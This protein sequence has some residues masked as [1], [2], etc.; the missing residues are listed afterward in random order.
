[1]ATNDG[2]LLIPV[3]NKRVDTM[4]AGAETSQLHLL[5]IFN[6]FRIAITPFERNLGISVRVDEDVECA[7]TVQHGQESD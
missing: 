3:A 7:V 1:M 4:I 6:L 2:Q 5:A